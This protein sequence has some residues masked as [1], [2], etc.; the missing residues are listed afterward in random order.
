[1]SISPSLIETIKSKISKL[2]SIQQPWFNRASKWVW[3]LL[4]S[5][6][7][8]LPLYVFTV[9]INLFG[10]Y[11]E[12][13]SIKEVENPENDLSSEI[14]SADGVSLGRYFRFN[15][16]QVT[17]DELSDDLVNTL[18][19]S[20][21]HRFYNHSGLDFKAYLRV[22]WGLITLN[23]AGG[24]S[25]ITQQLAKNLYTRNPD[26]SL[27]GSIAKLG[28]YPRRIVQKTKEW[29]ISVDL[30]KNFTKEEIISMYLNTAEFSSNSYGI[31]VAAETYFNKST[32]SLNLQES[33]VLVGMLQNPTFYNPARR[34][35]N[36]IEKRN[37]VLGKIYR[38]KYKITNREELDSITSLPLDLKFNIQN[39]NEGLATYFRTV[40]SNYL[41]RFCKERNI[42][43]WNSGLRIYTT[44]DSR[45]QKYAEESVSNHMS[46]L[47]EQ[48]NEEWKRVGQN[49]WVDDNGKEIRG[50][51]NSR[52]QRTDS[53][54]RL[55]EKYGEKS[56][57]LKIMLNLKRPMTV[58]TWKGERDTLFSYMDSLNHYKRFLQTGMMAMD[59]TTGDIK[60]WV[61]GINHKYFKYDHVQQGTRQPGST[62]KPFVYGLAMESG[63]SPCHPMKDISP[64]FK[65]SGGVWWPPNHDGKR[66]SGEEMTI[67]QAM[68][69]SIN[70]ITAQM[71]QALG[72][73][74]VV[75]FAQRVG[76]SSKLD[77]VPSLCLGT[78]DVSVY[79]LVGAY[80]TYVNGGI[81][82]EPFFISRIEDKHGNV[83]ENF[84]PKTRQAI[85]EQTAYK[86]IY[87]LMGGVEE[88]GGT[89]A[90]LSKDLKVDNEIGGKTGTTNNASDG[91]YVG[92]THDLVTGIW[93]GG[94]ERSI[95]FPSWT[96]GQGGRS[97]RPIWDQFMTQL[98]ADE[99]S[100]I[101]KG[102]FRRPSTG[103]DI[104]LDCGKVSENPDSVVIEIQPWDINN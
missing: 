57:S 69:R 79:E 12:M 19:L 84:V 93:V 26:K 88:S 74:N 10:L 66:G 23:P 65:V 101:T 103:L 25:T 67:R 82:T 1:M 71:M 102:K 41:M 24:G 32:D 73:E 52:I 35:E 78:S 44:I 81:F 18:L 83:I 29:I 92:L 98:Y 27:D 13:P 43:L 9:S 16:S 8:G 63:Y 45:I 96:F 14:I 4:L 68:A 85:N 47:Q 5:I 86:M 46:T 48:F 99:E 28:R 7:L 61:G 95:H 55:V 39:Q 6:L 89:S 3:M 76:I 11:G 70:S 42:D 80:S 30:E 21:D 77:P 17:F 49:P 2:L 22:I 15:R 97:A 75:E 31:K 53:Y 51:L 58:F 54:K 94:D 60:A 38:H 72:E 56:D 33:A 40:L 100:G 87:M 104:T 37:E 62:F 36:A 91:W 20:E 34:P 90:G 64:S 59:P 50:F